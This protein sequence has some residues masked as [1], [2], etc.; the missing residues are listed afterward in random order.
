MPALFLLCAL[1][2][3]AQAFEDFWWE[4]IRADHYRRELLFDLAELHYPALFTSNES[5]GV[6]E[7]QELVEG[8]DGY[9]PYSYTW[10]WYYRYYPQSN[11][12][13]AVNSVENAVYVYGPPFGPVPARAGGVDEVL[14][15]FPSGM[16]RSYTNECV[17]IGSPTPGMTAYYGPELSPPG[18]FFLPNI[19]NRSEG[20]SV[21][22]W[23]SGA[24]GGTE[25]LTYHGS[26]LHNLQLSSVTEQIAGL[27]GL[28]YLESSRS[29][30]NVDEA[31]AEFGWYTTS[32][33][34]LYKPGLLLG[35]A[36]R[37]CVGQA[38]LSAPVARSS[39]YAYLPSTSG[40]PAPPSS[41]QAETGLTVS[42]V[43]SVNTPVEVQ[44]GQFDTVEIITNSRRR[45]IDI[46]TGILVKEVSADTYNTNEY[47]QFMDRELYLLDTSGP[48]MLAI[49]SGN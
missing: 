11:T 38:W 15:L 1:G 26:F 24:N 18:S 28:T 7:V 47:D 45:W 21:V 8:G 49:C 4:E 9:D 20:D 2:T 12:Y 32:E 5:T 6:L 41:A 42:Y 10:N 25:V 13:L 19:P 39:T 27:A 29:T 33:T 16:N 3:R 17:E 44:A 34:T 23:K 14:R 37:F 36:N 46:E 30:Y 31:L 22:S 35:P 48:C 43:V 40:S